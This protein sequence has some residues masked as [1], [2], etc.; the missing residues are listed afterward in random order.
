VIFLTPDATEPLLEIDPG[1]TYAIGGVID[2]SV[3]KGLT[4]GFA[5]SHGIVTRR[6]PVRSWG[7]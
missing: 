3:R 7:V 2:R 1:K 6:L 5:E 4:L